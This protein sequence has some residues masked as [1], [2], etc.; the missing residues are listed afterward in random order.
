MSSFCVLLI[1]DSFPKAMAMGER[2]GI[3]QWVH[4]YYLTPFGWHLCGSTS[5]G[6]SRFWLLPSIGQSEYTSLSHWGTAQALASNPFC[7]KLSQDR[8]SHNVA[9]GPLHQNFLDC[10]WKCFLSTSQTEW[11]RITNVEGFV[12]CIFPKSPQVVLRHPKAWWTLLCTECLCPPWSQIYM[13]KP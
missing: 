3:G 11:I 12:I 4:L 2:M 10:F 8:I 1:K 5:V 6:T 13:L 7:L 9:S